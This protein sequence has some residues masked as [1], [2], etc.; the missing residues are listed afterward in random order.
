MICAHRA[1]IEAPDIGIEFT[2][3]RILAGDLRLAILNRLSSHR[4]ADEPAEFPRLRYR[5]KK[6]RLLVLLRRQMTDSSFAAAFTIRSVAKRALE[7]TMPTASPG[8]MYELSFE[9]PEF[10]FPHSPLGKWAA[11]Q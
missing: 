5:R 1:H 8:N 3:Q 2:N 10:A 4:F 11:G 7:A 9:R 6:R